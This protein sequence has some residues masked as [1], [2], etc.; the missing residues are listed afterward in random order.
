MKNE[1]SW[2]VA[3]S[4]SKKMIAIITNRLRTNIAW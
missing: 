1:I 3:K 2:K 4:S